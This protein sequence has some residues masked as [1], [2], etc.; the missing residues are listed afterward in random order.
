MGNLSNFES[1]EIGKERMDTLRRFGGDAKRLCDG[2]YQLAA[3]YESFR[4]QLD[5]TIDA[6]DIAYSDAAF[7][8]SVAECL[9]VL[10][11][12]TA[13][14]KAWL[15]VYLDGLGYQPKPQV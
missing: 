1:T 11:M 4:S 9:P 12:L 8:Y 13:E 2:M 6:E 5:E 14:Q 15:D 3:G 7:E 10:E